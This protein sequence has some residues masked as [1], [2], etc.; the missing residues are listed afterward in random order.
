MVIDVLA[1]LALALAALA[2]YAPLRDA[3]PAGA[4]GPGL[5]PDLLRRVRAAPDR[6]PSSAARAH[7]AR[8]WCSRT[9]PSTC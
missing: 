4:A 3:R 1:P 5:A 7:R 2:Y 8:S 9:W 6:S